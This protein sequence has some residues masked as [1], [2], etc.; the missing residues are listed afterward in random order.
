VKRGRESRMESEF[1]GGQSE[2]AGM[3]RK[4]VL[5]RQWMPP[6]SVANRLR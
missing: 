4:S 2:V 6:F 5:T 1:V 3:I